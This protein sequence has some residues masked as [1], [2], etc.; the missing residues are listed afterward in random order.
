MA[1]SISSGPK[2]HSL[3]S[4]PEKPEPYPPSD[5]IAQS[6]EYGDRTI[7]VTVPFPDTIALIAEV[8]NEHLANPSSTGGGAK[9]IYKGVDKQ[10]QEFIEVTKKETLLVPK[11]YVVAGEHAKADF[12]IAYNS[13]EPLHRA[14][15]TLTRRPGQD[16]GIWTVRLEFSVSKASPHGLVQLTAAVEEALP[17]VFEKVLPDFRVSRVDAAIDLVGIRPIDVIS[18]IKKPGKRLVY[19]GDHG[20]PE[21]L[22]LYEKRKLLKEPPKSLSTKTTGPFRLKLYER[23][24]Y[25]KQLLLEPPYAGCPVT[26]VETTKKWTNKTPSKRPALSSLAN[27]SNLFAGTHVAYAASLA[28]SQQKPQDW[29]AFCLA[30]FG[31]GVRTA[32]HKWP[33]G[34]GLNFRKTYSTCPGDLVHPDCWDRW[35]DGLNYTGLGDWIVLAGAKG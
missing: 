14:H 4:P 18:R 21:S 16:Y 6:M 23:R 28:A 8:R 15:L 10:L 11:P 19:V 31:G 17:L 9:K 2:V 3:T 29:L 13:V 12:W 30:A 35:Q 20:E 7:L 1:V 5:L 25:F 24:D 33:G 27:L 26:R 22:Y 32:Q 34:V